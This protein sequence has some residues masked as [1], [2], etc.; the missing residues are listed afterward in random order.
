MITLHPALFATVVVLAASTDFALIVLD[1]P[2]ICAKSRETCE[3][4][5]RAIASGWLFK[6]LR[7]DVP[8]RCEPRPGCFDQ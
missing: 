5:R 2:P 8:T 6:E 4:A 7:P 1:H 3:A